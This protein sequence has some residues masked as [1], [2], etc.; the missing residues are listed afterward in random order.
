M[1]T[2]KGTPI[3]DGHFMTREVIKYESD[4]ML[5]YDKPV[6]MFGTKAYHML[7]DISRDEEDWFHAHGETDDYYIGMWVT[8]MGFFNVLFP[9]NTSRKLTS[10]ELSH[11]KTL[12][13]VIQ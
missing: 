12:Q 10:D 1:K 11:F 3:D 2:N 5:E 13:F 8:G 7:G 6:V 4:N 9:I